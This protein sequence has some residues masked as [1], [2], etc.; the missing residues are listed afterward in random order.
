MLLLNTFTDK[1]NWVIAAL[2]AAVI[3]LLFTNISQCGEPC[4]EVVRRDTI[5]KYDSVLVLVRDSKPVPK[6]VT[7]L[8]KSVNHK[9]SQVL[10]TD[11]TFLYPT[12]LQYFI[13][14]HDTVFITLPND[15]TYYYRDTFE[16]NQVKAVIEETTSGEILNR[17][18]WLANLK[19]EIVIRETRIKERWKVYAG[20][21]V[22][23][24]NDLKRWGIAPSILLTIP[25]IGGI[26]YS[27]D[28][29]NQSHIGGIY[30]LIRIKK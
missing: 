3:F 22:I 20:A 17:K 10:I 26:S 18:V 15:S 12:Y 29:R 16:Q 27:Y 30:A 21:Q 14:T 4:G 11:S 23:V 6:R 28:I 5:L 8:K 24:P 2:T 7:P 9:Q 19:P 13:K 1:K 25:K